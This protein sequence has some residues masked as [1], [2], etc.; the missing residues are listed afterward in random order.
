MNKQQIIDSFSYGCNSTHLWSM[1][2]ADANYSRLAR[3]VICRTVRYYG[4]PQVGVINSCDESSEN[5][6]SLRNLLQ[7][8]KWLYDHQHPADCTNKRFAIIYNYAV[9][10]FGSII[11]QIAWAFGMALADNRIAVYETPGNWVRNLKLIE[12]KP[13]KRFISVQL[14]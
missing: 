5:E 9:A 4:G 6:F 8:Q 3:L 14:H 10:G 11:H 2:L 7:A 1:R 12:I 13:W